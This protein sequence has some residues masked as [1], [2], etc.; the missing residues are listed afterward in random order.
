[1]SKLEKF[2][3]SINTKKILKL[4]IVLL[5]FFLSGDI[6]V[7]IAG[8][9]N[10]DIKNLTGNQMFILTTISD[11]ILLLIL[12]IIYFKD[13]KEDFK[14]MKK[15]FNK[16]TEVG[17]KYWFIGILVMVVSNIIINL[18]LKEAH[19]NNEEMVQEV[20]KASGIISIIV[21]GVIGPII[22]EL[23]FRKAFRDVF[24]NKYAF[25]L[26]SGIVFGGLHV[27]L[28]I[29]SPWDLFYLI[30]YCSLG[31]AFGLMYVKTDNIYTSM[32]M[33]IFH[34]T[35]FTAISVIGAGAILW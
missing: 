20:I 3:S 8:L 26:I 2:K 12:G 9:L 11:I 30:P 23:V 22:E 32:C 1:M 33:H 19:A 31:I 34:N 14:I 5:I 35:V 25:I 24:K 28:S 6:K 29:T 21:I 15:D 13:L 27:I 18:F 10:Y 16:N 4:I 7:I 17:F